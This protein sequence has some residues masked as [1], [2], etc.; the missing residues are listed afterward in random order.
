MKFTH[1]R[2]AVWTCGL[3]EAVD[4]RGNLRVAFVLITPFARHFREFGG[5]SPPA[6]RLSLAAEALALLYE[7]EHW[8]RLPRRIECCDQSLAAL[9]EADPRLKTEIRVRRS[10]KE[11]RE[12]R[13]AFERRARETVR[14]Q[15]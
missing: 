2:D 6:E 7:E 10:L 11:L 13:D 15:R 5:Y 8:Y 9:L 4:R 3:V 12:A 1:T 14:M